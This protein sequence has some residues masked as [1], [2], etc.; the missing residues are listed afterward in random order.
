MPKSATSTHSLVTMALF[1]AIVCLSAYLSIPLPMG[2][3][4][5][6][7]NFT[8]MLVTLL[9]PAKQSGFIVATW[10]LIGCTGIPVYA[11][12]VGGIG[13]LISQY[14]GYNFGLLLTSVLLPLLRGRK[15]H[16][17]RYTI[18][19]VAGSIIVDII[20]TAWLM[21]IGGVSLQA[22]L[23]AGFYPFIVFDIAKAVTAAQVVPIFQRVIHG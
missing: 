22:A 12:G 5:T 13:Y 11:G 10:L 15:Y 8:I 7:M 20:G 16:R 4:L 2:T 3:H 21:L 23:V 14:G 1:T 19:S 6:L 17:L 9:F 18:L